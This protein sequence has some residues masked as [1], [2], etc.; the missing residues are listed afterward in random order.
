MA[1]TALVLAGSR[2]EGALSRRV[3][4]AI[5]QMLAEQGL[6][7]DVVQPED[8]TA[9]LYDGDIEAN[10]GVPKSIQALN[11]RMAAADALV[12][13]SPEYNAMFPPLLKNTLDWM[14]RRV[15]GQLG[16]AVFHHKPAL[17]IATSRGPRGGIRAL[18]HLRFQMAYFE[19]QV[20]GPQLGVGDVEQKVSAAGAVTDAALAEEMHT[21]AAGFA[22]FCRK[23]RA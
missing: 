6:Q 1:L 15:S 2:R 18:P 12:I 7:P 11:A 9:P 20:Y 13:V 16:G 3:Q 21:L 5:A 14:S 8:L 17:L 19:M 23:L 22:E 10:E 4:T